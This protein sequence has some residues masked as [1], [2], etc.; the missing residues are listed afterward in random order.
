[1]AFSSQTRHLEEICLTVVVVGNA[2][3]DVAYRVERL[4]ESGETVLARGR[5]VDVGGKG[6]NQAIIAHRGGAE[7]R[8]CAGLGDDP[9]AGIIRACLEA[10]GLSTAW[11]V[12]LPCATDESIVYVARSGENCI[13]STDEA[14]KRLAPAHVEGVLMDVAPGDVLL[15]QGNLSREVT[16]M[17]LARAHA[18]QATTLLNPAPIAFDYTRLWPMVDI[19]ILNQIEAQTLTGHVE[20]DAA[21]AVLRSRGA[22]KVV[23][24]LGPEGALV[25]R[26]PG[27]PQYV[28]ASAVVAVD[29]T[30]A[31]DVLAGVV[32][33]GIDRGLSLIPAVRWAVAAASHKVTRHGTSSGFP[34]TGELAALAPVMDLP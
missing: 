18:A 6:L 25:D 29:T 23:L 9:A 8:F 26:A 2:V 31:G 17:C 1:V 20:I 5:T 19:A 27:P 11:L 10:E 22:G 7:V 3:V 34:S 14:V 12:S 24:T 32:A 16:G 33:A 28:P 13:V 4:P 30:G 15:L 21:T